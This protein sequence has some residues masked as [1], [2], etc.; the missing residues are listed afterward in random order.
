[1]IYYLQSLIEAW[2]NKI[3][4]Q[5]QLKITRT[6]KRM[7]TYKKKEDLKQVFNYSQFYLIRLSLPLLKFT[8]AI[9]ARTSIKGVGTVSMVGGAEANV[10][11]S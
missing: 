7:R 8:C 9:F 3:G 2:H 4:L 6:E 10:N 11:V 1:M 5:H